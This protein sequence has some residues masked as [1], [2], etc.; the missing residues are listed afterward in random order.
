MK[1]LTKMP[2]PTIGADPELFIT[3]KDGVP[4]AA[5]SMFPALPK[6]GTS[7]P[8]IGYDNVAVEYTIQPAQCL[9]QNN[10]NHAHQLFNILELL[11]TQKHQISLLPALEFPAETLKKYKSASVFGCDPSMLCVNGEILM[12]APAPDPFEIRYRSAG[13]HIH[14]GANRVDKDYPEGAGDAYKGLR[15]VLHDDQKRTEIIQTADLILGLPSVILDQHP[16]NKIRRTKLGYGLAGEF[17]YQ[18]YGLEYRTLSPWPLRHP[19]WVWWAS[20]SLR[21]AVRLVF[22]NIKLFEK[23]DMIAVSEII[24]NSDVKAAG[25]LWTR[26]KKILCKAVWQEMIPSGSGSTSCLMPSIL[27]RAEFLMADGGIEHKQLPK[28]SSLRDA[29]ENSYRRGF[30]SQTESFVSSA[31]FAS[32]KKKWSPNKDCVSHGL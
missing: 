14:I 16:A 6:K 18:P 3:D 19:M 23:M 13:F 31:A 24:N 20:S 27:Q 9:Q 28:F 26:V 12:G 8:S 32:F 21:D 25:P 5:E 2:S 1:R 30:P 4:L 22:H 29:W 17:R 11:A 7:W 10:S 15:A